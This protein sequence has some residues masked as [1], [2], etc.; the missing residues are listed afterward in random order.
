MPALVLTIDVLDEL[1]LGPVVGAS[2]IRPE[3]MLSA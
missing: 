2:Q 1:P 3:G